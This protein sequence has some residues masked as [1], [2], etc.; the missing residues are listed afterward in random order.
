[1][2]KSNAIQLIEDKIYHTMMAGLCF[3]NIDT[4]YTC[5]SDLGSIVQEIL[6]SGK[7]AED[8]LMSLEREGM[9][10]PQSQCVLIP[11]DNGGTKHSE[12]KNEWEPED[13]EK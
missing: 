11:D 13:E 10:P 2:K 5:V 1:M 9:Q 7:V 12:V 4:K 6:T 3:Y 8:I